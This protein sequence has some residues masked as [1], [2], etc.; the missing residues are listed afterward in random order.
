MRTISLLYRAWQP[1]TGGLLFTFQRK[2]M[3]ISWVE[4]PGV[5]LWKWRR[6]SLR[7]RG[8]RHGIGRWRGPFRLVGADQGRVRH[9]QQSFVAAEAFQFRHA[10][11]CRS[12]CYKH[13]AEQAEGL[14]I[15]MLVSVGLC[16]ALRL[17]EGHVGQRLRGDGGLVGRIDKVHGAGSF[18]LGPLVAGTRRQFPV[19]RGAPQLRGHPVQ[20]FG[21]LAQRGTVGGEFGVDRAHRHVDRVLLLAIGRPAVDQQRQQ[22]TDHH[23]D[24]LHDDVAE[25]DRPAA[26]PTE[27]PTRTRRGRF[28]AHQLHTTLPHSPDAIRSKP[29]WK[30]SMASWWVSTFCSGKP[31]SSI[32]VILYQ[33]S[34][35]RRP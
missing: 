21:I 7:R 12:G 22:D 30:S 17:L 31:V 1:A 27:S 34:Y 14:L 10:L 5:S 25:V 19:L 8:F 33:V 15:E 24:D 3:W 26:Q 13:A 20:A 35:M 18:P 28:L 23:R 16:N 9:V 6:V 4:Y 29:C 2:F 32:C 11:A